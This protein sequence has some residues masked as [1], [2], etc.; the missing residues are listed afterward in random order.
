ML[1]LAADLDLMFEGLSATHLAAADLPD[2]NATSRRTK[3]FKRRKRES[4]RDAE[5]VQALDCRP[6]ALVSPM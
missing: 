4:G 3:G 1:D 5:G 2:V 6:E